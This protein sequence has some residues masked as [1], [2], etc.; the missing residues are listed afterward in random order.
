MMTGQDRTTDPDR[1]PTHESQEL[2]SDFTWPTR[3]MRQE[4][5]QER[6]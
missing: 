5:N 2:I 4:V 6:D 1:Q 3:K